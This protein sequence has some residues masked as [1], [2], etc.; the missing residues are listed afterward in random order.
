MIAIAGGHGKIGLMLT[1]RLSARGEIVIGL[2]RTP[3]QAD[4]VRAAGGEPRIC[5]LEQADVPAVTAAVAGAS[6]VL[7]AAG[8][9]PGSGPERKWTVDR[10]GATKLLEAA[11]AADVPR[12]LIISS[13]G[14][15]DPPAGDDAFSV[16]LRAKAQAD[17][18]VQSSDRDWTIVRPGRLTDA[19]GTERVR[20][21]LEAFRGEV[22]RADVAAVLDGLLAGP[23]AVGR[24]LYV[25]GG[26]TPITE[27]LDAVG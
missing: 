8:A 23:I 15:E 22:A 14:A 25:N 3:E 24:T 13:V 2:I 10:D 1:R 21:D 4:D 17:A 18:A 5:D 20:I 6:A 12:Y 27:A 26:E 11:G 19:P 9:G 7:F 16:Y